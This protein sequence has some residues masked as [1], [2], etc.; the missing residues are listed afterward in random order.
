MPV[1]GYNFPYFHNI[2]LH[3][4]YTLFI[5]RN[6]SSAFPPYMSIPS[7][8]IMLEMTVI[9]ICVN[10]NRFG[11]TD[12]IPRLDMYV[13]VVYCVIAEQVSDMYHIHRTLG[14]FLHEHR[15]I[16]NSA[17]AKQNKA[18]IF[19]PWSR[20]EHIYSRFILPIEFGGVFH[21]LKIETMRFYVMSKRQY[22][23]NENVRK[24]RL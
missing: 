5:A 7:M 11:L 10:K 1:D 3:Q 24:P 19:F 6:L 9:L 18:R 17:P 15:S 21:I 23:C 20:N 13:Y 14:R 22:T 2:S 8:K 16:G 4:L 12:T